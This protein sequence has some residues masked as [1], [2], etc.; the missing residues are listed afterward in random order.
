MF[1]GYRVENGMAIYNDGA[2]AP[3]GTSLRQRKPTVA[4]R[5]YASNPFCASHR[6]CRSSCKAGWKY[7]ENFI[8][9]AGYRYGAVS[10]TYDEPP[11]TM[12]ERVCARGQHRHS[13]RNFVGG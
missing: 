9:G 5:L 8:G 1:F 2:P 6:L 13:S 10:G 3:P 7:H 11:R 12:T 4:A